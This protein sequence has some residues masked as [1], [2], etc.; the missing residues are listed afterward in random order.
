MVSLLTQNPKGK[1]S[2]KGKTM[3][4]GKR[5]GI[6]STVSESSSSAPIS[7]TWSPASTPGGLSTSPSPFKGK[8]K[9]KGKFLK[10]K[11]S[12]P[13]NSG[14]SSPITCNFC[15][16]H[17]HT[18]RNCRKKNALHHSNSYQQARS[19]FNSRQ[20]LV[21]DQLENSLFA[22]NVCSWCL[23]PNCNTTT[24]YPPEDPEFYTETTHLFQSTLLPYVQNAKLGLAVDNA[25]PL[26]PQ[27]LAFE[28]ADWG[29]TDTQVQAFDT[30]DYDHLDSTTESTWDELLEYHSGDLYDH[31]VAP[32][33]MIEDQFDYDQEH[34]ENQEEYHTEDSLQQDTLMY[35]NHDA[36]DITGNEEPFEE[37]LQ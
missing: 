36:E 23:Q 22:P 27:H 12:R 14:A 25:A 30:D 5:S 33:Q 24:C 7:N 18:E 31:Y 20:Q 2:G 26:M 15:H 11:V 3:N 32:N 13:P 35:E 1:G 34:S 21:M 4:K 37:D 29:Q 9:Q 8:G 19:Q 10:G 28:G 17:G 6:P 16:L